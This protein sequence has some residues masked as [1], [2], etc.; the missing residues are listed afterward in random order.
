MSKKDI[1][2]VNL[3]HYAINSWNTKFSEMQCNTKHQPILHLYRMR[4]LNRSKLQK[5][6]SF[7]FDPFKKRAL[8][9][10]IKD[11]LY[12]FTPF[13]PLMQSFLNF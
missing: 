4:F 13:L 9:I 10:L 6:F 8:L 1:Y 12:K 11:H 5:L 2:R 7:R 3:Q